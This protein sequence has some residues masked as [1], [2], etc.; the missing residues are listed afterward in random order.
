MNAMC[1]LIPGMLAGVAAIGAPLKFQ[2]SERQVALVELYTSEG[3]SSCPPAESWLSGLKQAPTLWSSFV[4]VAFHVDYWDNLGWRDKWSR[5]QYT[6]RQRDYA[7]AWPSDTIYTPEFVLNGRE[8]HNWFGLRGSPDLS[9]TKAGILTVTTADTKHYE[10]SFVPAPGG[11]ADYEIEAA[12]LIS[13]AD[14]SVKAGENAG[15][16]L[17]HDFVVADFIHQPL[18]RKGNQFEGNFVLPAGPAKP[19]GRPALAVWIARAGQLQPVQAT[20][21]W[22]D[23]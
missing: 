16:H 9:E 12:L 22:L 19:E 13:G 1:Y 8:W 6:E 7:A 21:G 4:P 14:S 20:G 10:A 17:K 5:K 11:T 18:M 2:S 3:C 15:R 23:Q